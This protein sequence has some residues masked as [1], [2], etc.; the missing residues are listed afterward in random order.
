MT[1]TLAAFHKYSH[2]VFFYWERYTYEYWLLISE[3]ETCDFFTA[4]DYKYESVTVS[5]EYRN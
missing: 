5:I 3:I 2:R 4:K 1:E